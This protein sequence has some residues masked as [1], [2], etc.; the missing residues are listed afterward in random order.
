MM[1]NDGTITTNTQQQVQQPVKKAKNKK[2][3]VNDNW[4]DYIMKNASKLDDNK[5]Y[6]EIVESVF[7]A[8]HKSDD[9]WFSVFLKH[10]MS[11]QDIQQ[12]TKFVADN[13]DEL[14]AKWHTAAD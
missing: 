9:D 8:L 7:N 11:L 3:K 2:P 12:F 1:Y 13:G 5:Q 6:R 10:K 4:Y 14:I